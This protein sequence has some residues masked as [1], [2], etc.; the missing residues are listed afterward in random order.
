M[1]VV[2]KGK[3]K[4]LNALTPASQFVK[5]LDFQLEISISI[6]IL[7]MIKVIMVKGGKMTFCSE[8]CL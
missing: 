5:K 8:C 2:L 7:I 1:L 3:L 4:Q 6:S